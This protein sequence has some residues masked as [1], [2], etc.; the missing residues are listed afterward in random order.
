MASPHVS[1]RVLV[2]GLVWG[3]LVIQ[4]VAPARSTVSAASAEI[5][6][7]PDSGGYVLTASDGFVT[8]TRTVRRD[9]LDLRMSVAGDEARLRLVGRMLSA[10]TRAGSPHAAGLGRDD[11]RRVLWLL[12]GSAAV[13]AAR[14]L[15]Q[16]LPLRA[17]RVADQPLLLTRALLQS[18]IGDVTPVD[19]VARGLRRAPISPNR[20][21][22]LARRAAQR[23]VCLSDAAWWEVTR[24]QVCAAVYVLEIEA[25]LITPALVAGSGL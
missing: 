3:W 17:D 10:S 1:G 15:L 13:Q 22:D 23:E 4:G 24:R 20:A 8:L 19:V 11:V 21:R 6:F 9:S 14:I 16:E 2:S 5:R 18:L 25:D 12:N 7:Q